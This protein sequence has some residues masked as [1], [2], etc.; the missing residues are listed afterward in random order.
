MIKLVVVI[1]GA[2]SLLGAG[3]SSGSDGAPAPSA[4]PRQNVM[5][6]DEGI[7]LG[8]AEFHGK[9]AASFTL[10]CQASPAPVDGDGGS[11]ADAGAG[12]GGTPTLDDL[13]QRYIAALMTPDDSCDLVPGI[14]AKSDPLAAIAAFRDRWNHMIRAQLYGAAVFSGAQWDQVIAAVNAELTTFAYHGTAT[15]GTVAHDN[16]GVR[17]V[18]VQRVLGSASGFAQSF[19][20][21]AQAEIDQTTAVLTDPDVRSAW[22][23]AP[24]SQADAKLAGV[25]SD[26]NVG[27]VSES[28]GQ[29]PRAVVE[30][31]QIQKGCPPVDLRAYSTAVNDFQ[32][33]R[34]D[35]MRPNLTVQAAG[36]ESTE[37]DSPADDV[38]C[39]PGD[40]RHLLV[41]SYDLTQT[42]SKFTNFGACVDVSAP[43]EDIIAPYAGG[44][45]FPVAGTSFAAPL[46]AR[47]ISRTAAS[48]Y[49]PAQARQTLLA[50]RDG[51]GDLSIDLFPRDF[52]YA[53]AGLGK[54]TGALSAA[55]PAAPRLALR[56]PPPPQVD[57]RR[58]LAPIQRLRALRR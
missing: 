54:A 7:D 25:L 5:V 57:L 32:H 17:L 34:L 26:Y 39:A 24:P 48:P 8:N 6:I 23:Q 19:T 56:R 55:A 9:V 42:R 13:K 21:L 50:Q 29:P 4:D 3:C 22:I 2:G 37:I 16:P 41:G 10:D 52:F 1:L 36:N 47:Q 27:I 38:E 49:D 11:D 18:L 31:L 35:A 51:L 30:Q 20:C 33:A 58:W 53:P 45:L 15:A 44:W 40:S 14:D 43:G 12:D 28:Y 46:V